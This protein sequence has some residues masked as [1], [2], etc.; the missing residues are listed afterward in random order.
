MNKEVTDDW[1]LSWSSFE[2]VVHEK[3]IKMNKIRDSL[4]ANRCINVHD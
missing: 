1:E 4:N 3:K 2:E